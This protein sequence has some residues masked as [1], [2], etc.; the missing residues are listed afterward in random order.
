MKRNVFVRVSGASGF[1]EP[2][3]TVFYSSNRIML[4]R[5]EY[6]ISYDNSTRHLVF[7]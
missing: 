4:Y 2:Y 5:S 7:R 6:F 1:G 3:L